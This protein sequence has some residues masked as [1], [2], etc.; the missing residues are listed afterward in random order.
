MGLWEMLLGQ[1][2]GNWY[3]TM[4][5]GLF[6]SFELEDQGWKGKKEK[7]QNTAKR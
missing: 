3:S 4:T 5:V 6:F 7:R 1:K 2:V